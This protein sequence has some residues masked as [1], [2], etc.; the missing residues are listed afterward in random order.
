MADKKLRVLVG[1]VGLDGHDVGARVV[2]QA[3]ADK[4]MWNEAI[5]EYEIAITLDPGFADAHNGL[6]FSCDGAD[7]S[8]AEDDPPFVF[9]EDPDCTG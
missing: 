3:L 6:G 5:A 1:K 4:Q 8:Q 9:I 7:P 2:A